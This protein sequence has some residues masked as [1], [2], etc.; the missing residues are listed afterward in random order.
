MKKL[1][2]RA[3]GMTQNV[4]H[5]NAWYGIKL[6][7]RYARGDW[8]TQPGKAVFVL[9]CTIILFLLATVTDQD[10][11]AY[12]GGILFGG[13][14]V[15]YWITYQPKGCEG[16]RHTYTSPQGHVSI[17][18]CHGCQGW[19]VV[20]RGKG[21][22]EGNGKEELIAKLERLVETHSRNAPDAA[23]ELRQAIA[24]IEPAP[25][26]LRPFDE[27]FKVQ[28][29]DDIPPTIRQLLGQGASL[30]PVPLS[31]LPDDVKEGAPVILSPEESKAWREWKDS[32]ETEEGGEDGKHDESE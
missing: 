18:M 9:T 31:S 14:W 25:N 20:V 2:E 17:G 19:T 24:K 28:T 32:Q 29:E 23:E 4:R 8:M 3:S 21:M 13:F 12:A 27:G 26:L 10:G 22:G 15:G 30:V 11:Y 7:A 16:P 5:G 6:W 1:R